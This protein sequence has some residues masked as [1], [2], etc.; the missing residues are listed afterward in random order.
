MKKSFLSRL[1]YKSKHTKKET[2]GNLTAMLLPSILGIIICAICLM[3]STW[4]WFTATQSTETQT[5]QAANYTVIIK[6]NDT[7]YNTNTVIS[8]EKNTYTVTL[9]ASGDASTGYC[10]VK[11]G[12]TEKL[13]QQFPSDIYPEKSITFT[14]VVN[15]ATTV[16][17]IPWWGSSIVENYER[18]LNGSTHTHG[19]VSVTVENSSSD[20]EDETT[21]PSADTTEDTTTEE[22]TTTE[23]E[24]TIAPTQY[25]VQ[26]GDTLDK[27]AKLYNTTAAILQAYNNIEDANYIRAG[28]TIMIP[29]AGWQIPDTTTDPEAPEIEGNTDNIEETE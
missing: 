3:G 7:Q 5:I 21:E 22:T 24:L 11:I 14:L 6:L 15:E 19:T 28:D 8:L 12:N 16:E 2:S 4:A 9:T 10:K 29:P 13:T 20:K 17:F 1:F 25:V 18:I 23:T 27:I 26:S